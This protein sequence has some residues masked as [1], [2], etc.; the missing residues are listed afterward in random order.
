MINWVWPGAG[1]GGRLWGGA[2]RKGGR[3]SFAKGRAGGV[4]VEGRLARQQLTSCPTNTPMSSEI[5]R[6]GGMTTPQLARAANPFPSTVWKFPGT[7]RWK[8]LDTAL[9]ATHGRHFSRSAG[10]V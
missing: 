8:Y 4:G 5:P 7:V 3:G 9:Q 6:P 1:E 2:S 10:T